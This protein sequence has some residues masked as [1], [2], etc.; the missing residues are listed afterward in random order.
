MGWKTGLPQA[1]GFARDLERTI[2]GGMARE[3]MGR[4]KILAARKIP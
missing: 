2:V 4:V 3:G 1:P